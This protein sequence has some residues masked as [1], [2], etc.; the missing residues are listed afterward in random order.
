MDG[1]WPVH[2][3]AQPETSEDRAIPLDV[4]PA[5]VVEQA[6]ATADHLEQAAARRVVLGMVAEMLGERGDALGEDRDLDLGRSRVAVVAPMLGDD[7]G[8]GADVWH[9]V[10]HGAVARSRAESGACAAWLH[11]TTRHRG[12]PPVVPECSRMTQPDC[13]GLRT[14]R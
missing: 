4:E 3:P 14:V 7:L 5:Q 9:G 1:R 12:L 2:L 11:A 8:F 10:L 6:A 13:Q